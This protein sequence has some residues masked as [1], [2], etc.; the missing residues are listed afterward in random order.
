LPRQPHLHSE[1]IRPKRP[2]DH[3]LSLKSLGRL[4]DGTDPEPG[5]HERDRRLIVRN[6]A[7]YPRD[8]PGSTAQRDDLIVEGRSVIGRNDD[9]QLTPKI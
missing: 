7:R 4:R 6:A 1:C 8:E 5:R 3:A 9:E 2:I